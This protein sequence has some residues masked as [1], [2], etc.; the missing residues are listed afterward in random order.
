MLITSRK[1]RAIIDAGEGAVL[2]SIDIALKKAKTAVL[3]GMNTEGL[4]QG[5]VRR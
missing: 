2:G 3:F 5:V 4:N 1:A